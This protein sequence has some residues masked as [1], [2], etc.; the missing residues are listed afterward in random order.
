MA[1]GLLG[2]LTWVL[3]VQAGQPAVAGTIRDGESGAPLS[4][5]VVTLTDADRSVVTDAEG[6]YRLDATAAGPQH[7]SVKRIG[8]EPRTVHALVPGDGV[9]RLD[10]SLRPHP[11]QLP[12]IVVRAT[13]AIRGLE[14][15]EPPDV[16]DRSISAAALRNHPLLAEPDGFLALTGGSVSAA[17]EAPEGVHLHGGASDHTAYLLDGIPVF[18]PYHAAGTFSAWNPDALEQVQVQSATPSLASPDA[19]AGAVAGTTRPPGNELRTYGT[20]STSHARLTMHGPLGA[21]GAG[22]LLSVRSG[23]PGVLTPDSDL[24]Y[25]QGRTGDLLAKVEAPALRGRLRVLLYDSG[26]KLDAA[27]SAESPE[28][29]TDPSRNDFEWDSRSA[30]VSWT[31]A[32]AG[33]KVVHLQAWNARGEAEAEWGPTSRLALEADREDQGLLGTVERTSGDR[34]TGI[35]VRIQRSRTSYRVSPRGGTGVGSSLTSRIPIASLLARHREPLAAGL[36][37]D[38]GLAATAASGDLHLGPQAELRWN[39]A[40]SLSLAGSYAHAHQFAQ[41]LRNPESVS[42]GIFPADLFLGTGAPG[43]PVARSDR[44]MLGA[45]LRPLPGVRL[46]TQAYLARFDGLLLVAPATGRPFATEGFAEGR[47]T[48]KGASVEAAVS[49]TWYGAL[50]SWGLQDVRTTYGASSY[51]PGHGTSHLV[52]LGLIVFPAPTA[53]VRLGFTGALG[54]RGTGVLGAFEWESCNL[55]DQGCEFAGSPTNDSRNPGGT[56]LPDYLRLDIGVRKHWHLG[57]GGRDVELGLFGTLTNLFGR[58]NVLAVATDP[59]TGERSLVEMRPFAPL[60]IGL[61]WRF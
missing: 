5:A 58:R 24:S 34:L 32:L 8:Y 20:L 3:A 15:T 17:P 56:R 11:L 13:V 40:R 38:V 49:G 9:L 4:G 45:E 10:L 2:A 54:R 41:S 1:P 50:A 7:L 29:V 26:N 14:T 36:S 16:L 44:M 6:R 47:G 48:A 23:F 19:L 61:D 30:G 43:V 57:I 33:G 21:T 42:G 39:P 22:F 31:R 28:G 53:S 27:A 25:L 55:L 35:G 46:G 60:V 37:A 51:V 12:T 59:S 18:S 52:E